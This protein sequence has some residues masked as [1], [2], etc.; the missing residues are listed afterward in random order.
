MRSPLRALVQTLRRSSLGFRGWGVPPGVMAA[1]ARRE[2]R[3]GNGGFNEFSWEI[4]T[5]NG[6]FNRCLNGKIYGNIQNKQTKWWDSIFSFHEQPQ[7]KPGVYPMF[8]M[9]KS[10]WDP[11][12]SLSRATNKRTHLVDVMWWLVSEILWSDDKWVV[13][14]KWDRSLWKRMYVFITH[15]FGTLRSIPDCRSHLELNKCLCFFG[16]ALSYIATRLLIAQSPINLVGPSSVSH[17]S[18]PWCSCLHRNRRHIDSKHGL[19]PMNLPYL[20]E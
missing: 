11:D 5:I 9:D 19:K 2:I 15:Q 13:T 18:G 7:W 17:R 16:L 20:G 8:P 1:M 3:I 10:R 12:N 4:P 14:G 6:G